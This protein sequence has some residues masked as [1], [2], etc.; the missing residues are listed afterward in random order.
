MIPKYTRIVNAQFS[1]IHRFSINCML[2]YL[3]LAACF[4]IA[5]I[6]LINELLHLICYLPLQIMVS[7]LYLSCWRFS[8]VLYPIFL[9]TFIVTQIFCSLNL[10][11]NETIIVV[12]N[13][14]HTP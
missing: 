13:L 6:A 9:F 1:I 7:I 11:N 8:S 5:H 12:S 14:F 2:L 3:S 10:K 4:F